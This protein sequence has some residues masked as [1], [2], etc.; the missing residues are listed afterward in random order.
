MC[1]P[2]GAASDVVVEDGITEEM[3]RALAERTPRR[4]V[5]TWDQ[6]WK[7]LFPQDASPLDPGEYFVQYMIVAHTQADS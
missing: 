7:L 6:I 1:E 3:D 4:A 5:Q 2:N